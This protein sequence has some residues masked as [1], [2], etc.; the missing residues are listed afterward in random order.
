MSFG[1]SVIKG[2][3]LHHWSESLVDCYCVARVVT[4]QLDHPDGPTLVY[5]GK[6]RRSSFKNDSKAPTWRFYADLYTP[7]VTPEDRIVVEVYDHDYLNRD[8]LV[9]VCLSSPDFL[10]GGH[11]RAKDFRIFG[12]AESRASEAT[13][14]AGDLRHDWKMTRSEDEMQHVPQKYADGRLPYHPEWV[15]QE[16]T[17]GQPSVTIRG[18]DHDSMPQKVTVYFVRHGESVWN[19]SQERRDIIGM[20]SEVDHPLDSGGIEQCQSFNGAWQAARAADEAGTL[21]AKESAEIRQFLQSES[22]W[23]SPLTRAAQTCLIGLQGHPALQKD[24][25][26]PHVTLLATARE[27]KKFGGQDTVSKTAGVDV[28]KRAR[29]Q[30]GLATTEGAAPTP[31]Y[32]AEEI[33]AICDHIHVDTFDACEQWWTNSATKDTDGCGVRCGLFGG[34]LG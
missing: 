23:T 28:M 5:K 22:V 12:H 33:E 32:T 1:I 19:E 11:E 10:P 2:Q 34:C 24:A 29:E 14:S 26:T 13:H 31:V 3:N 25:R 6:A 16:A 20:M 21:S 7:D 15:N 30:M 8:D 17:A 4:P 27:I 9:G 18:V